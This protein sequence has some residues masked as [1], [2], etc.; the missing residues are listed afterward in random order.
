[1]IV[2]Y[3]DAYGMTDEQKRARLLSSLNVQASKFL[4]KDYKALRNGN[5]WDLMMHEFGLYPTARTREMRKKEPLKTI[6]PPV[7]KKSKK[8]KS[9]IQEKTKSDL[10]L[11][12][13]YR[14]MGV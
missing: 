2:G 9:T 3:N 6:L 10:E 14:A 5:G 7:K 13:L 12:K 8:K 1:M 4:T 11:S